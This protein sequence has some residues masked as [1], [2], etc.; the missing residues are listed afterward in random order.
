MPEFDTYNAIQRY[1]KD[2][3]SAEAA[4]AYVFLKKRTERQLL[5]RAASLG[6]ADLNAALDLVMGI[7]SNDSSGSPT[8]LADMTEDQRRKLYD[9]ACKQAGIKLDPSALTN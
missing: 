7:T 1:A 5:W 3:D 9:A 8:S 6:F 4:L 2:N